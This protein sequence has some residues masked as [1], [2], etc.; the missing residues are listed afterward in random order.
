MSKLSRRHFLQLAGAT[1]STLGLSK[2]ERYGK[3]LAQSTP[4]KVALLVGINDYSQSPLRGC[5]N[6]VFMQ[7]E[8]L[9]HRFGFNPKDIHLLLNQDA[10]RKG[11]LGAFEEYLINQVKPE[12]VA[13]YHYSGHGSRIFDPNPI[14][15]DFSKE[16]S[17]LNGTFV[18]IDATLPPG[19]PEQSGSVKDI[20]GH[21]LYLLMSAVP[22]E[23]FTAVLDSCFSGAANRKIRIRSRD[24]GK[25]TLVSGEEKA[26]QEQLLSKLNI[27]PQEFIAGYRRGVAKGVV[28]ASTNPNQLAA[29]AWINGFSAGAFTYALTQYLWQEN[30][31][32]EEAIAYVVKNITKYLPDDFVQTPTLNVEVGSGYEEQPIYFASPTR[33]A[34]HAIVTRI[35]G[36]QAKFWLGGIDPGEVERGMKFSVPGKQGLVRYQTRNGLLAIGNVEGSVSAGDLLIVKE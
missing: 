20:M 18:P 10:T 29:D 9:I 15:T 7:R 28:I 3:V 23:N 32:P 1:L 4:R 13:V 12:D 34:A 22:T 31:N 16:E 14:V 26:Y 27:S 21:T 35:E 6:D 30:T 17:N 25:E 5:I 33:A 11:M 24:G 8:L 19:Y 36:R 2:W